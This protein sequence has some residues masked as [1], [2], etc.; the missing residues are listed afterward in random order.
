MLSR[1]LG[2]GGLEMSL[3]ATNSHQRPFPGSLRGTQIVD[4]LLCSHLGVPCGA[5]LTLPSSG[6]QAWLM[7]TDPAQGRICR[8][9]D[10][11]LETQPPSQ[12]PSHLHL[13]A[14]TGPC[15]RLKTRLQPMGL[16]TGKWVFEGGS[17]FRAPWEPGTREGSLLQQGLHHGLWPPP[18]G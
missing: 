8:G 9:S 18:P 4:S 16:W 7:G 13:Q 1:K 6:L 10:R 5:C 3:V 17:S 15:P 12:N 11:A 2:I 14:L